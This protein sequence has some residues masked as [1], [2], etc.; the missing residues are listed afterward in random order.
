MQPRYLAVA[1]LLLAA[2]A[3]ATTQSWVT[4]TVRKQAACLESQLASGGASQCGSFGTASNSEIY[5]INNHGFSVSVHGGIVYAA[6]D[7]SD[8]WEDWFG[9]NG[10]I[11]C[12]SV[13]LPGLNGGSY[14]GGAAAFHNGFVAGWG[15][16]DT[17]FFSVLSSTVSNCANCRVVLAG[18][19]RGGA[20]AT[21]AMLNILLD[22]NLA[23]NLQYLQNNPTGK[24]TVQTHGEPHMIQHSEVKNH[25]D[26]QTKV[27]PVQN[28][29]KERHVV[30]GY[31]AGFCSNADPVTYAS[32]ICINGFE[33]VGLLVSSCDGV[34]GGH[35]LDEHYIWR[36]FNKGSVEK[37]FRKCWGGQSSSGQQERKCWH[38]LSWFRWYFKCENV[39]GGVRSNNVGQVN[40]K[41]QAWLAQSCP[42]NIANL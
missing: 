33:P 5:T 40:S 42:S 41:Y 2:T 20:F 22:S 3:H 15:E 24:L 36:L 14:F 19:S 35:G 7:S 34:G 18:H 13:A 29:I 9:S 16:F 17:T 12:G 31:V 6:F 39:G 10:N 1:C 38:Y 23:S 4:D 30:W 11:N 21:L 26:W 32:D 25:N 27:A 28:T 8:D 37:Y